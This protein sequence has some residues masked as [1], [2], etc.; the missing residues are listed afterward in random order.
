[1]YGVSTLSDGT[2]EFKNLKQGDYV[3]KV[4]FIGFETSEIKVSLKSDQS[5]SVQLNPNVDNDR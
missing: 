4:S 3:V 1:M 5:I 2:F